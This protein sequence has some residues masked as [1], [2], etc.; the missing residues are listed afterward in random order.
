MGEE[1]IS[2]FLVFF[3]GLLA[4]VLILSKY[5]KESPTISSFVPEAAMVIG[6]GMGAGYLIHLVV[7]QRLTANAAQQ[8]AQD[9]AIAYDDDAAAAEKEEDEI[10]LASLLSFSPEMF[11]IFLLPPIIFNTGLRMGALFFRHIAPIVMFAVLGTAISAISTAVFLWIV[12][13]LGLSG[14][15][16]PSIAEL[17]TFGALISSTDPVSTLAVFQAKRVDPRLFYLCFG[18]SVLNDALAIVLF[19]SFGKFV[20]KQ[21][22]TGDVA[23]AFGEFF[24][25]LFL[26]SVGSLL[27]GCFGGACA[28]FLFKRIDMR[29]NRLSEISVLILTMYIPFLIAEILHLSGIVTILFTGITANRYVVPNLSA[30]T[31]VNADMVFRLGAHLSETAIF[32]ELGLSVF[33]MVGYW[34]WPFIGFSVLACL[35]AR[36]LN[37][38]PLSFLYNLSLL[39]GETMPTKSAAIWDR[40]QYPQT[41]TTNNDL[42]EGLA[43]PTARNSDNP[44]VMFEDGIVG[45]P[46]T[47][48]FD[49]SH[50]QTLDQRTMS[51]SDQSVD[52]VDTATPWERKDLKIR[53]NTVNML[54]FSGLRGAVAYACVRTF[55]NTLG[56]QKD[57]AMTTMAVVLI[58]VFLLGST[59][60][61]A[62]SWFNIDVN[63]DEKKYMQSCVRE[64]IVSNAITNFERRFIKPCVI[65]DFRIMES[66]RKD[67]QRH[68]EGRALPFRRRPHAPVEPTIEMTESGYLD[69]VD[70]EETVEK[71]VRTDSLFDYGA[72]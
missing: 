39:R 51:F 21:H 17:L 18:E 24:V 19:Y 59:T 10:D 2:V 43:T 48:P 52:T 38:Y 66:I 28:G 65:R 16:E 49:N 22:D 41:S 45:D 62:L 7:G 33:G 56:H 37:V 8:D 72:Y 58:T 12:V 26:N 14:G 68:E 9:D 25:D 15:F 40:R 71:L 44:G 30:I 27:L 54:W 13:K 70:E 1:N 20:S 64:P 57:F 63:V 67:V 29:Q 61:L 11:F 53:W 55:P 50:H 34:N 23:I 5:V 60:E 6:V 42:I 46:T 35:A 47:R 3:V 4:V 36:A 32:L 31:K 69:C